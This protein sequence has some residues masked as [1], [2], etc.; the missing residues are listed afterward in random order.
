MALDMRHFRILF[1]ALLLVFV[2][3]AAHAVIP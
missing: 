3:T 2:A 1:M